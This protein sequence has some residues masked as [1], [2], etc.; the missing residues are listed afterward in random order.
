[1][2]TNSEG[3]RAIAAVIIVNLG[4]F[5][6]V[7]TLPSFQAAHHHWIFPVFAALLAAQWALTFIPSPADRL[8]DRRALR[9]SVVSLLVLLL[10]VG[11]ARHATILACFDRCSFKLAA[12]AAIAGCV[13][14][15]HLWTRDEG[16]WNP[17]RASLAAIAS[18]LWA[19]S[20]VLRGLNLAPW[21]SD[22]LFVI[23]ALLLWLGRDR[24]AF[25]I[26]SLGILI[27]LAVRATA[28]EYAIIGLSVVWSVAL[29][30]W[31][32]PRVEAFIA[33]RRVLPAP[34]EA[35]A[36]PLGRKVLMSVMRIAGAVAVIAGIARFVVG[37]LS[38]VTDPAK[39]RAYLA[40]RAPASSERD[41]GTL[42]PLAARLRAHVLMLSRTI[43]ERDAYHPK[44]R[45]R[46]RDYVLANFKEAG[47]SPKALPYGS[48]WM[49]DVKNGTSFQNV[50]AV[51]SVRA[52][53]PRGSW[54]IGAHYDS[55]PGTP[56]ADDNASGVAVLLEVARL[57]KERAPGREVR[58]VAFGTEEPPS[59]GTRNMGSWQY[60]SGLKDDGVAVH[61]VIVL[62]M[63]GYYNPRPGSQLYPPF[64]QLFYPDHG[65]FVGAVGNI[66]SRA[67][68][69]EFGASWKRA[70][71][72]PL[73]SSVLPGPFAGLALS[74]Q[75]NFWDLGFPALMLSD[76]AFYRN[77]NY[78]EASDLP[79]TLDY[80]KMAEV[81]KALA[82][83][84][85][86]S[87]D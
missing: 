41:P 57:L 76:T 78:H 75:L 33:G 70:S 28:N 19:L 8:V 45:E 49:R 55:A 6:A 48:R 40:A 51:L 18:W 34:A 17:P 68:L 77:A 64:M 79:E 13:F 20:L 67:L 5:L 3:A 37:P 61:G 16:F 58:F 80:E 14:L 73:T 36:E 53:R 11:I 27:A 52:P 83:A 12:A 4:L 47:Y 50:E 24:A 2:K 60:A 7:V 32:A 62:E 46:A 1:M 69:G 81:A 87:P 39:R 15:G 44:G 22:L 29:P 82:A 35:V 42:T 9:A 54:V 74:D 25:L 63:L 30:L 43:G 71:R 10:V 23:L 31:A 26:A 65:D 59:F 38:L 21:L 56:G 72:F 86:E 85:E 84:V 66:A